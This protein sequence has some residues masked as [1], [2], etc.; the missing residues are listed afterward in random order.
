MRYPD[1]AELGFFSTETS[2]TGAPPYSYLM[3][4]GDI[5]AYV[6]LQGWMVGHIGLVNGM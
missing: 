5:R 2:G 4:S 3:A 1:L 6:G